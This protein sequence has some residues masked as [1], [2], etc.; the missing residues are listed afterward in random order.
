MGEILMLV[1]ILGIGVWWGYHIG[2]CPGDTF[3]QRARAYFR[4]HRPPRPPLRS[5]D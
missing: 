3:E 4:G 1:A 5:I 2:L